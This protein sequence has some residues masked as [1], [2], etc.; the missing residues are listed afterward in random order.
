MKLRWAGA[1]IA[2]VGVFNTAGCGTAVN[3]CMPTCENNTPALHIYGGVEADTRLINPEPVEPVLAAKLDDP[4]LKIIA[5]TVMVGAFLDLPFSFVADTI[6]LPITFPADVYYDLAHMDEPL[7]EL[8][9]EF[10][11]Y[12]QGE[13]PPP[14]S[15]LP[16]IDPAISGV[17]TPARASASPSA[18]R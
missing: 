6:T 1:C 7:R 12:R 13:S 5:T 16:G 2:L 4:V 14:G 10:E 17:A 3:L 9:P 15:P 11:K 18:G 8:N